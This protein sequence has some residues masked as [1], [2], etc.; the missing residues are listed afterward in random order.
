MK[1]FTEQLLYYNSIFQDAIAE[2]QIVST[3][4]TTKNC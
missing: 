4:N 3:M 1:D 2:K